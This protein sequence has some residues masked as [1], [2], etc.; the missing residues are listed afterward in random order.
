MCIFLIATGWYF[1]GVIVMVVILP[2]TILAIVPVTVGYYFLMLH[3]RKSGP[4]LQ[5]LDAVSRSPIQAM[6]SEGLD[7]CSTIRVYHKENVFLD[8]FLTAVNTNSSALLNFVTAQRW[9]GIRIELLGSAV[10]LVCAVLVVCLNQVLALEPG[11]VGLLIIWSSNFTITL[12]FLVDT[13]GEAEAAIT[14]IERVDA[15][16]SLPQ[17]RA[18]TTD[19]KLAVPASWPSAGELEFQDVCLRYRDGLP[20]ALNN[21]S[22]KVKPGQSCGV[23]GRTGK[24]SPYSRTITFLTISL[25]EPNRAIKSYLHRGWKV[26]PDSCSF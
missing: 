22:F 18:M 19:P 10:V 14:A 15:M 1:A 17:E 8:K 26:E 6:V 24:H 7:G 21:L 2:Y 11:I 23:V 25:I 16:S 9:L 4:D 3:Y 5:R 12:G 13:F 20:L